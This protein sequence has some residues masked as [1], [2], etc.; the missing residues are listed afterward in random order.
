MDSGPSFES[1][2]RKFGF[3]GERKL[4]GTKCE[5]FDV[6]EGPLG[7]QRENALGFYLKFRWG[8]SLSSWSKIKREFV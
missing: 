3:N 6:N 4:V 7:V 2:E 8:C 1:P 5:S